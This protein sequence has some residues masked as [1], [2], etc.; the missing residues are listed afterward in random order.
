LL[1]L[2]GT[3]QFNVQLADEV[4]AR[5]TGQRAQV[6]LLALIVPGMYLYLRLMTPQLL[7]LLDETLIGRLILVPTAVALEVGGIVLSLRITRFAR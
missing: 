7:S 6:W 2:S 4:R 3:V 5:S 1:D